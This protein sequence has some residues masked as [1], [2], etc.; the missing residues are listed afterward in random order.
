MDEEDDEEEGEGDVGLSTSERRYRRRSLFSP[1]RLSAPLSHMVRKCMDIMMGCANR[2]TI[3]SIRKLSLMHKCAILCRNMAETSLLTGD[4]LRAAVQTDDR[5][6]KKIDRLMDEKYALEH[7]I[8]ELK[9][10]SDSTIEISSQVK[11]DV[12]MVMEENQSLEKENEELKSALEG[13]KKKV[14]MLEDKIKKLQT[15][16]RKEKKEKDEKEKELVA[17]YKKH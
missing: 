1:K 7:D 17:S 8:K 14:Q 10:E 6:C 9:F 11:A 16:L 12:E 5:R 15:T 13:E 3:R 4:V 2:A